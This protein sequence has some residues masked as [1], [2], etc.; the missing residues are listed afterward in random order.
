MSERMRPA[1]LMGQCCWTNNSPTDV[2]NFATFKDLKSF[3]S[4]KFCFLFVETL[5]WKL[6]PG[7]PHKSILSLFIIRINT[8][9]NVWSA[10]WIE[11]GQWLFTAPVH[12]RSYPNFSGVPSSSPS[13]EAL[14]LHRIWVVGDE[15]NV[16]PAT[17]FWII[18]RKADVEWPS[19]SPDYSFWG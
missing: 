4:T 9:V 15:T 7:G 11:H 10:I 6:V 17:W 12:S 8:E 2:T 14:Y 13:V 16:F 3:H 19:R 5:K 18:S 1:L